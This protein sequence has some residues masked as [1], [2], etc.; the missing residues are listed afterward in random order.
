MSA[1]EGGLPLRRWRHHEVVELEVE[2]GGEVE[3]EVASLQEGDM[4]IGDLVSGRAGLE[5]KAFDEKIERL[6]TKERL[7]SDERVAREGAHTHNRR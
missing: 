7:I 2:V 3:V 5:E 1:E 6:F 4:A